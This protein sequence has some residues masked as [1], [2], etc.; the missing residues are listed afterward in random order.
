MHIP[1]FSVLSRFLREDNDS[2]TVMVPRQV[3]QLL[4]KAALK[5]G[6][7]DEAW[8]FKSYPDI[9]EAV[10]KGE[11]PDALTHFSQFGYFEGR[12]PA[13]ITVNETWYR[14]Q[15]P[16]VDEAV[17]AGKIKSAQLHYETSGFAEGRAPT[18]EA[19]QE[20]AEWTAA[21]ATWR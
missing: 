8:Y 15:Y 11:T 2:N 20:F 16:D 13:R 5:G 17:R 4:L 7:F 6:G 19:H 14:K 12:R 3:L 9:V 21:F 18:P 10:R 1:P